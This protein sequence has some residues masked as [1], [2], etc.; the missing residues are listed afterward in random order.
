MFPETE[1][2]PVLR[3]DFSDQRRWEAVR[4]AVDAPVG[5]VTRARVDFV[6]DP[7]Y[8]DLTPDRIL[9]LL[10]DDCPHAIIAVADAATLAAPEMPLLVLDLWA[11]R[12][13]ELRC[14]PDALW[15][16]E[17]NTAV[18]NMDF[19]EFADAVDDDGVF[20]GIGGRQ[21]MTMTLRALAALKGL[22]PDG[23]DPAGREG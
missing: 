12:G 8:A 13:R 15:V 16:V 17:S 11:E 9:A 2:A 1:K 21:G 5:G 23:G 7:A 6:D 19:A 4:A 10:P 20:R 3:T 18:G 22:A 14:V